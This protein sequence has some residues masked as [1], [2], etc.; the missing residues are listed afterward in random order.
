MDE[1][2]KNKEI[3]KI[4]EGLQ[5]DHGASVVN[6][7]KRPEVKVLS[8][9]SLSLDGAIGI[10]GIPVGKVME[11]YGPESGGKTSI[12]LMIAAEVQRQGGKVFFLDAENALDTN[13][14]AS[15]FGVNIDPLEFSIV[16]ENMLETGL[17]IVDRIVTSGLYALVIVDSVTA[18]SP[19]REIEGT[20]D[21]MTMG[22]QANKMSQFMRKMVSK[23]NKSG[24]AVIFI[25]QLRDKIGVMFGSPETT[26][27]GRALKFYSSV[28]M[29]VSKSGKEIL[30][31][32][33]NK[34]G[35]EITVRIEKNKV[36]P[37]Y[38]EA[39]LTLLYSSGMDKIGEIFDV[40]TAKGLITRSGPTYSFNGK[41]WRG[42]EA[43]KADIRASTAL[44]L[45][46]TEAIKAAP[47]TLT[48][49]M[50][51]DSEDEKE[52]EELE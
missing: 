11:L 45:E 25:N 23:I 20:M 17:D 29:R 4:F 33:K 31:E 13:W 3:K 39:T 7:G 1:K 34:I 6:Y 37:P 5:K 48:S 27:G 8:T 30:D 41:S 46:L 32:S 43:V 28:R 52:P 18:L 40:A 10:G 19:R 50:V 36:G 14:A 47:S 12:S 9:G 35:H 44:A 22:L 2:E 24:T 42:Q 21:Q 16:Q 26:P 38:K 49:T 51:P 15:S